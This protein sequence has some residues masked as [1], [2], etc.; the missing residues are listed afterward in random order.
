MC[1]LIYIFFCV[2]LKIL[3][4]V[5]RRRGKVFREKASGER[6]REREK[7]KCGVCVYLHVYRCVLWEYSS[8][9]HGKCIIIRF[10]RRCRFICAATF[11]NRMI[12]RLDRV[13]KSGTFWCLLSICRRSFRGKSC[14]STTHCIYML[15]ALAKYICIKHINIRTKIYERI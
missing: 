15:C 6:E 11:P 13:W 1:K 3:L 4:G 14:I 12:F 10:L 5:V 8:E 7:D 2:A 9:L